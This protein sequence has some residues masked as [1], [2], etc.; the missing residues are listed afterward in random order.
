MIRLS[1]ID[2]IRVS[3]QPIDLLS[4]LTSWLRQGR[5]QTALKVAGIQQILRTTAEEMGLTPDDSQLQ[6]AADDFRRKNGILKLAETKAWLKDRQLSVSD[7]EAIV[8]Q[9][10]IHVCVRCR[11]SRG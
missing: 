8:E 7:F 11:D 9:N 10:E 1:S 3:S 4:V 2:A 5:L 6:I